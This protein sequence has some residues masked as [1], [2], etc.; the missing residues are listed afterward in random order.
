MELES[1]VKSFKADF[2]G[3]EILIETGKLA[4]QAH[5]SVVARVGDTV[6][7][8]TAVVADQ[9]R[10]GVDFFPL[11]IDYEERFYASGKISGS[12]FIKRE[13]RP[14]EQAVL[15]CRLIDRPLRPLFPKTYRNDVQVII[16][17][18]SY[19]GENDPDL[20][21]TFAA[22]AAL[23]Q[24]KAPYAGPIAAC[25]IGLVEGK[26]VVNPKNS[27]LENSELDLV[28][29]ATRDRVMMIEAQAN[30]VPEETVIE[31]IELAQK[32]M[33]PLFDIQ[34][35]VA[36]AHQ[37]IVEE[38]IAEEK[39]VFEEIHTKVKDYVGENIAAAMK[40][41]NEELRKKRL[42][43]F[44]QEIL[45][46]FEGEYKQVDLKATFTKLV[47][48]EVRRLIL[49]EGLRPDGR[50]ITE[51]RSISV[52]V[53]LLPRTHGSALFTRGQTQALTV[54]T[55]A[56][57][58]MEQ[59]IDTMEVETTK[60]F[61]HHYNFPPFSTGEVSPVRGAS[62]REIGHGY[63]AEKALLPM[64]PDKDSF[65]YTV[66][67]VSE[68]L[69]SNG[70]SSMAATCG[71]TLALMDAGVPIKKPVAGVAMGLVTNEDASKYKVLTDLQ[72][73]EDFAG[74]MDF[75]IA[76]TD[77]GITA[78]QMDTK[79]HGLTGEIV[80]DTFTQAKEGRLHI[81]G[82]MIEAIEKPREELSQYAP[83]IESIKINP[84][85]IGELIGPGG[86]NINKI[87][88]DCGGKEVTNIDIDEDGTVMVS[89]T[90]PEM[91]AKA[92]NQI[93]MSM[94]EVNVGEV[95]TGKII[96]IKK[97]RMTGK[98]IG[99]IMEITPK[100]DGM[101]HISQIANTRV[102][103]IEDYVKPGDV[104][105]ARVMEVDREK[106]RIGLSMKAVGGQSAPNESTDSFK[107]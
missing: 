38:E 36:K 89:S 32:S 76:G 103:R 65:P 92:L 46:N 61:M 49:E 80:R 7:L 68:I 34:T 79:I 17:V 1:K 75:K 52:E 66:R 74:D 26:L 27:V 41:V 51:V 100:V 73:L 98:E 91:G 37:A 105:T 78:I 83:R 72:G 11:L 28:V 6:V 23:I 69:S 77:K 106:G 99:A 90:D 18:L 13:G 67:L 84:E 86:K 15:T 50:V 102:E 57:P 14:S 29:S 96:E 16:T 63:L 5:G 30:E 87:I 62:R 21:S 48:K 40:E 95:I 3:E 81:L 97:D 43:E 56:S 85:R 45:K 33:Q 2:F 25:R 39:D 10:E 20:I 22:S 12:R 19:D 71:S 44:E 70:S 8:A 53:G 104:V 94:R 101:I 64:M 4:E 59:L 24:T 47:Q 31:A 88:A 60:R 42:Q 35:V 107:R 55:L 93:K 58:G 82:K 54:A 9:Q